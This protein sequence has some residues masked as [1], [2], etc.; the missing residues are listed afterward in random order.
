MA[1]YA[2][3]KADMINMTRMLPIE[4][5]AYNIRVNSVSHSFIR[6]RFSQPIWGFPEILDMAVKQ[7]PQGRIGE[8][9]EVI[10][11]MLFMA[12]D[13]SSYVN[14][15]NIVVTGGIYTG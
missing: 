2:L 8:P 6:T 13:T 14:C 5:R 9:V 12:S 7:I 3:S 4:L 11:V 15:D 10:K 1:I